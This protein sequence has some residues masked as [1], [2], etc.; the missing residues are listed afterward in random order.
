M[1]DQ[2]FDD[3]L[4]DSICWCRHGFGPLEAARFCF[5]RRYR[6]GDEK[7]LFEPYSGGEAVEK[8][9]HPLFDEFIDGDVS[10]PQFFGEAVRGD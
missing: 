10:G 4:S 7:T 5:D 3:V 9:L 8:L 1:G 2:S 6:L